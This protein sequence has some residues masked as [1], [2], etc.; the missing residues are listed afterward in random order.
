VP[1]RKVD[2]S[3]ALRISLHEA[4][5]LPATSAPSHLLIC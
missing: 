4:T 5:A 1:S 3:T 2:A